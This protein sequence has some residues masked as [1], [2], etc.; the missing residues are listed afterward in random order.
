MF[1]YSFPNCKFLCN[2]K[3]LVKDGTSTIGRVC[4]VTQVEIDQ[5]FL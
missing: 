3:I 5:T 4:G 1:D 2:S